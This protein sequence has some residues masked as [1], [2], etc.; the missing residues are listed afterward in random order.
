[1]P[2]APVNEQQSDPVADQNQAD[3]PIP[4]KTQRKRSS[5]HMM[6]AVE[7]FIFSIVGWGWL[8][9]REYMGATPVMDASVILCLFISASINLVLALVYHTTDQFKNSAQGF[10]AHTLSIWVLYAYSLYEST[11]PRQTPLCCGSASTFSASQTYA[12]AYFGGLPLHQTVAAVTLAFLSV[13]LLLAAVQVRVC[14]EDPREWLLM[15]TGLAVVCLVSFQLGL[16]TT[17]AGVCGAGGLGVAVQVTA[18]VAWI[19]MIDVLKLINFKNVV[20][21]GVIQLITELAL[22][23]MLTAMV[24]VLSATVFGSASTLL[25]L[26]FGCVMLWQSVALALALVVCMGPKGGVQSVSVDPDAPSAPPKELL[27]RYRG[28]PVMALPG[29]REM[30]LHGE[31]RGKKAW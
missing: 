17:N 9:V 24:G 26:I 1:M 28:R 20:L 25:M 31:R 7:L 27:A 29:V 3:D 2:S 18:A 23:V 13:F 6:F 5:R 8:A 21:G 30:R 10:L 11:I 12:A 4:Q 16:F 19:S 22:T 14:L 15:K